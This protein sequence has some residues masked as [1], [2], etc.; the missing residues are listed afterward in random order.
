MEVEPILGRLTVPLGVEKQ[1]TAI[2]G[3]PH[4][5]H[6]VADVDDFLRLPSV[7]CENMCGRFL[8]RLARQA[9]T[10]AAY[11]GNLAAP[12]RDIATHDPYENV[13]PVEPILLSPVMRADASVIA[14]SA[15]QRRNPKPA[16]H[17]SRRAPSRHA[18]A[19]IAASIVVVI[20]VATVLVAADRNAF[21]SVPSL[22]W[23]APAP[24]TTGTMDWLNER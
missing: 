8:G 3:S 21:G 9:I 1:Q 13:S 15:F 24:A 5:V 18:A 7:F 16:T 10:T 12:E 17:I 20:T 22:P 4:V 14:P 6:G 19:K 23:I 11:Q 2:H